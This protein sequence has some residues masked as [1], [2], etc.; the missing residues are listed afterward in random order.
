MKE[1]PWR[2]YATVCATKTKLFL[3]IETQFSLFTFHVYKKNYLRTWI[4][5]KKKKFH[6]LLWIT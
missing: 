1:Q 6:Y 3:F 2:G 5:K 4:G